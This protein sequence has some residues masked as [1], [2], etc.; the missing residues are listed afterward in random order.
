MLSLCL[1]VWF[2]VAKTNA[3]FQEIWA[4]PLADDVAS[5]EA[6]GTITVAGAP[7]TASSTM[8]VYV[9]AKRIR[10]AALTTDS[11]A[12][13]AQNLTDEINETAGVGAVA[14]SCRMM[15]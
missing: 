10:I 14:T 1:Q 8:T 11:N 3:P 4:L 5:V 6:T 9:N 13:V 15:L 2:A 12:D 7:L